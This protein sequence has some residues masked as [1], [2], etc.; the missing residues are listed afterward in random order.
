MR[1]ARTSGRRRGLLHG[2]GGQAGDELALQQQERD[3]D[4]MLT[5]S[6]AAMIWFQYTF[7]CVEYSCR[8]TASVRFSSVVITEA[9][10]TSPQLVMKE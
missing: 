1:S 10:S 6:D 9:N 7:V 5:T 8:P 2:A 3:D 4:G